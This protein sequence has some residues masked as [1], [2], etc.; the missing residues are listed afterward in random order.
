MNCRI[1]NVHDEIMRAWRTKLNI[2]LINYLSY[3]ANQIS[4]THN[5]NCWSIPKRSA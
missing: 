5:I 3:F 2:H 4:D 1:S